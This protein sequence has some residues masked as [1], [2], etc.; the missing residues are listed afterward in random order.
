MSTDQSKHEL[1]LKAF[2]L[3]RD[4]T[5]WLGQ[6]ASATDRRVFDMEAA[7]VKQLAL[8]QSRSRP[9]IPVVLDNFGKTRK[10]ISVD[11]IKQLRGECIDL[12]TKLL[13]DPESFGIEFVSKL[14]EETVLLLPGEDL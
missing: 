14:D 9:D 3:L 7:R 2:D 1:R 8:L 6:R 13:D 11:D 5:T 12:I 10:V 4:A